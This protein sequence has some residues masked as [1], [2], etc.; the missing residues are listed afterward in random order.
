MKAELNITTDTQIL[1]KLRYCNQ[2]L[3]MFI[4]HIP[5]EKEALEKSKICFESIMLLNLTISKLTTL[6]KKEIDE[7]E[8]LVIEESDDFEKLNSKKNNKKLNFL[9]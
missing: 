5:F 6:F 8:N 1:S 2:Q 3:R 7:Y 4:K 9:N